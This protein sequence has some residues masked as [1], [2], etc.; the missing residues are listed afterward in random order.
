MRSLAIVDSAAMNAIDHAAAA[1][2]RWLFL[3]AIVFILVAGSAIVRYLVKS[4]AEKD[5]S[6]TNSQ[7]S[8]DA[9]HSAAMK[10]MQVTQA[11]F[12]EKVWSE[13][14]QL[15]AQLLVAMQANNRLLEENADLLRKLDHHLARLPS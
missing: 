14:I 11:A 7:Q 1:T 8:K 4:L 15:S 3:A 2:D 6:H 12:V 5:V 9:I 10:E 13:Q